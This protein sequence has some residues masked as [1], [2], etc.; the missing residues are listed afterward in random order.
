MTPETPLAELAVQ[1][2][3]ATKVFHR[4]GLDF[5]CKGWR[6]LAAACQSKG[7]DPLALIKEIKDESPASSQESDG[8]E[9]PLEELVDHIISRYHE[10]LREELPRF[11]A[12]AQK[13]ERVHQDKEGCPRGLGAHLETVLA[14][15]LTHLDKE[16]RILF[17]MIRAGQAAPM[18]VK[19]MTQEHDDHAA[20]LRRIRELTNDFNPP[21]H[22]CT[23]WRALYMGLNVFEQEL[24]EHIHLENYVLFPRSLVGAEVP[25]PA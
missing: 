14:E 21:A 5:C 7:L 19:A 13:V 18:P 9:R 11:L 4:H 2:P 16:E 15:I 23:T 17:P 3:A 1:I 12:M 25:G 6:S 8:S 24:M 20:H 22:A 10:P